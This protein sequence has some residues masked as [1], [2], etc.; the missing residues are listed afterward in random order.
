MFKNTFFCLLSFL[1]L[2]FSKVK[3]QEIGSS[4]MGGIYIG[5][6]IIIH[7]YLLKKTNNNSY[8]NINEANQYCSKLKTNGYADWKVPS[9]NDLFYIYDYADN[10]RV[11]GGFPNP[12][13][14]AV[15][16]I[17]RSMNNN[18]S[19]WFYYMTSKKIGG[20]A[21]LGLSSGSGYLLPVRYI[22]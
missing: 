9:I 11:Y 10:N 8:F 16:Y 2:N 14:P 1:S 18:N 7:P 3:S 17:S 15:T 21:E 22:R 6:Q 19:R 4:Y 5:N 13:W 20:G 12:I